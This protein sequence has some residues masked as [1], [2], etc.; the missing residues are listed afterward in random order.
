MFLKVYSFVCITTKSEILRLLTVYHLCLEMHVIRCM[1]SFHKNI[2]KCPAK[3]KHNPP[4][5]NFRVSICI[6]V[7]FKVRIRVTVCLLEEKSQEDTSLYDLH[8]W[9]FLPE[10]IVKFTRKARRHFVLVIEISMHL[11]IEC[12]SGHNSTLSELANQIG[13]STNATH[14]YC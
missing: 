11:I 5:S 2:A 12:I 8:C 14:Q 3:S 9:Y 13:Q 4:H 7:T 10:V 1:V 6:W